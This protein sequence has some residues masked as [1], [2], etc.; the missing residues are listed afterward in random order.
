MVFLGV[1]RHLPNLLTNQLSNL[2]TI[3]HR[4]AQNVSVYIYYPW[5]FDNESDFGTDPAHPHEIISW[6]N[7]PAMNSECLRQVLG[8]SERFDAFEPGERF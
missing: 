6:S 5:K 4:Q 3:H 8:H 2:F 1:S 7:F